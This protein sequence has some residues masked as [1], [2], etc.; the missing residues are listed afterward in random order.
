MKFNV[1]RE[2]V[3]KYAD[4]AFL[5]LALVFLALAALLWYFGGGKPDLSYSKVKKA[6]DEV[7]NDTQKAGE[8]DYVQGTLLKDDPLANLISE[9]DAAV[10][11][12]VS[13][14]NAHKATFGW[15]RGISPVNISDILSRNLS[16]KDLLAEGL[17][18]LAEAAKLPKSKARTDQLLTAQQV[19]RAVKEE[20][21]ASQEERDSLRTALTQARDAVSAEV[22]EYAPYRPLAPYE[23]QRVKYARLPD[24]AH[25]VAPVRLMA[26]AA[27]GYTPADSG[28][29]EERFYVTFQAQVDLGLQTQW[30]NE[31]ANSSENTELQ[32]N[33]T[34]LVG[35]DVQVQQRRSD[36][37]W[38]TEWQDLVPG[39]DLVTYDWVAGRG[40]TNSLLRFVT[41]ADGNAEILY[42]D[43]AKADQVRKEFNTK[44]EALAKREYEE[45]LLRPPFF[46]LSGLEKG[47]ILPYDLA[48]EPAV[49]AKPEESSKDSSGLPLLDLGK[50]KPAD[51]GDRPKAPAQMTEITGNHLLTAADAGKT[52]RYRVRVRFLNPIFGAAIS[53]IDPKHQEE[54][55]IY[56]LAGR[57]SEPSE[58]VTMPELVKYFFVGQSPGNKANFVIKRWRYGEW[59]TAKSVTVG[60]GEAVTAERNETIKA[61]DRKGQLVVVKKDKISY[62]TGGV[63]LVDLTSSEFVRPGS[64]VKGVSP[65]AILHDPITGTLVSR[66]SELDKVEAAREERPQ[67]VPGRRPVDQPTEPTPAPAA[68]PVRPG[69]QPPVR[70]GQP[71]PGDMQEPPPPPPPPTQRPDD[72]S[73]VPR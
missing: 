14:R 38:P 55:W 13:F 41:M 63:V 32:V 36:G 2:K 26:N 20:K 72:F 4:K 37:T 33:R 22:S 53:M 21:L 17:K 60:I 1:D 29:G 59:Y 10:A 67:V 42:G 6:V 28:L 44:K 12:D 16:D 23:Q 69:G 65:K 39:R 8:L 30:S 52:Y 58:P 54:G 49:P 48:G 61:K 7:R 47:P 24:E 15:L 18:L 19:L 31:A 50:D 5:G 43:S 70:P 34:I 27:Y 46:P 56:Q 66:L 40:G 9:R 3:I 57:W 73:P 62:D 35:Y 71:L 64:L 68:P 25:R 45:S 11:Y 51:Q